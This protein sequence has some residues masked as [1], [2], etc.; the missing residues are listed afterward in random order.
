MKCDCCKKEKGIEVRKFN[1]PFIGYGGP[2]DTIDEEERIYFRLCPECIR[3]I[4][5]YIHKKGVEPKKFWEMNINVD[6]SNNMICQHFEYEDILWS[7]LHKFIPHSLNGRKLS[8]NERIEFWKIAYKRR[9][10]G[11]SNN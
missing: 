7:V 11:G 2:F 1:V 4:N 10:K 3:T 8:M 5:N 9:K 6:F